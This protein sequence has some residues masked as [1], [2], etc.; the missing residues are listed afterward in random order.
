MTVGFS[1]G[2]WRRCKCEPQGCPCCLGIFQG[3]QNSK[4]LQTPGV[5]GDWLC[6]HWNLPLF[7]SGCPGFMTF[8]AASVLVTKPVLLSAVCSRRVVAESSLFFVV[9]FFLSAAAS[10]SCLPS[11][12]QGRGSPAAEVCAE[13]L[14]HHWI[15]FPLSCGIDPALGSAG[16]EEH[17]LGVV[18]KGCHCPR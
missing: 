3:T 9:G 17:G 18:Q 6:F 15:L 4:V 16:V 8:S 10:F 11:E 2:R 7:F 1:L 13:P 14:S 12:A 5:A